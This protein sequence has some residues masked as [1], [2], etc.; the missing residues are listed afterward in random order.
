MAKRIASNARER[1]QVELDKMKPGAV[2]IDKYGHVW[3]LDRLYWY[4]PF[5]GGPASSW[6]LSFHHPFTRV[7][8][9]KE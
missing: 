5:G 9:G 2:V 1:A 6:D 8:H 7:W 3:Q 4:R